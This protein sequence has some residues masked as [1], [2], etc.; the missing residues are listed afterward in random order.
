MIDTLKIHLER[1]DNVVAEYNDSLEARAYAARERY[2]DAKA[3]L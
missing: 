2:T 1:I 3:A